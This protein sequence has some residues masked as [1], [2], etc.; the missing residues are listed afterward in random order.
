MFWVEIDVYYDLRSYMSCY[1]I[2][3]LPLCFNDNNS[4]LDLNSLN[5]GLLYDD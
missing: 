1:E 2:L 3:I 5:L 4:C